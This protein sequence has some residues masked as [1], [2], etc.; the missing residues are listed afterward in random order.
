MLD[1]NYYRSMDKR[2]AGFSGCLQIDEPYAE[3]MPF[4]QLFP[5]LADMF[6]FPQ[7]VNDSLAEY[8]FDDLQS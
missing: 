6:G 5:E 3:E 8:S 7:D 4:D 1:A 2:N